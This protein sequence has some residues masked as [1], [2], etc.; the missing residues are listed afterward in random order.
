MFII[1]ISFLCFLQFSTLAFHTIKP[2]WIPSSANAQVIAEL[3]TDR[4]VMPRMPLH[5]VAMKHINTNIHVMMKLVRYSLSV[6][7]LFLM[8]L[9]IYPM[10]PSGGVGNVRN[11][12][13]ISFMTPFSP[14]VSYCF[15]QFSKFS[16][17]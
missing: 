1:S 13:C 5:S 6:N 16:L 3:N 9:L 11:F 17:A 4:S 10:L 8:Y 2:V 14:N 15:Q 12:A 7:P